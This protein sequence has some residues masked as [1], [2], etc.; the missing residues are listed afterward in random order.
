VLTGVAKKLGIRT[1]RQFRLAIRWLAVVI[2]VGSGFAVGLL[3]ELHWFWW[4]AVPGVLLLLATIVEFVF[5]DY[6]AEQSYPMETEKKIALLERRLG[7][8]AVQSIAD[9]LTRRIA[10]FQACD[11][12]QISGTVHVIVELPPSPEMKERYGLLQLTNYVGPHGGSKGRITTLE[13][14]IIGRCARTGKMEFVNFADANEYRRRMVEEFGFSKEE[15]ERHTTI[16]RSYI[17]EPLF[18]GPKI[19]GVL[20]FFSSEPQVF[21]YAADASDLK[22]DTQDLVDLLKTV[23]IV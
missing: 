3:M 5:G 13:K 2:G 21:P 12:S 9:K 15:A 22:S 14:G 6:I 1:R 23:S 18:L 20:Y 7:A 10:S 4:S 16:A 17:A 19:I 11:T 8:L